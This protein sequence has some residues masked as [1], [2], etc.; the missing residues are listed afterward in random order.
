MLESNTF[1][2]GRLISLSDS[3]VFQ[4]FYI[5]LGK[6]LTGMLSLMSSWFLV[7]STKYCFRLAIPRSQ[8]CFYLSCNL[9]GKK[10]T[11]RLKTSSNLICDLSA[12]LGIFSHAS[13]TFAFS[14]SSNAKG[15]SFLSTKSRTTKIIC[16][17][18]SE[19]NNFRLS[20]RIT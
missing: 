2:W 8:F 6:S 18:F 20:S 4:M 17:G 1:S 10:K 13:L 5:N 3:I 9:E 15:F 11:L 16:F 19:P 12:V 14:L 7:L